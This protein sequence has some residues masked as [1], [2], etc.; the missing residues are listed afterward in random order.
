MRKA[1][2]IAA[3][4]LAGMI[5]VGTASIPAYAGPTVIKSLDA[6]NDGTLDAQEIG[7]AAGAVFDR[8]EKDQDATLDYKELG[9]RLSKEDFAR[10]DPDNDGTLTKEEYVAFV[11]RLFKEADVDQEGT[12]DAAEMNSKAGQALTRLIE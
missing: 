10:A 1:V 6:D 12:V 9:S 3:P 11:Q 7:K 5:F 2:F 4:A 8:L